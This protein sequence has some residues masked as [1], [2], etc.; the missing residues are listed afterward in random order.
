M[1]LNEDFTRRGKLADLGRWHITRF[2]EGVAAKLAPGTLLLDAG[3]GEC[4]YKRYFTHCRYVAT[5]LAVGEQKWNYAN[6][7][8][9]AGLDR[10]PLQDASVD[11]VL[12]TQVL[13]HLEWPRECVRE[14]FRVLKPG[15]TLFLTAPMSHAEH[16]MPHDFFR[17]T[18]SGLLSICREAGFAHVE[19]S[20]FGGMWTRFAY[21]LPRALAFVPGTGL[22]SGVVQWRGLLLFPIRALAW[23]GV[24]VFQRFFL[25]AERFDRVKNDTFGWSVTA[26]K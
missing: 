24:R 17:Y 26:R 23:L 22:R 4:A 11:A 10:L 3:A 20:P 16:Q 18:S 2:V 13:E 6:V 21:E 5:D 15:G 7:D 12:C 25:W 1:R 8:L 19:I 14:F 9:F